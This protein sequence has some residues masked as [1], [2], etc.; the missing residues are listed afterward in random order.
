MPFCTGKGTLGP[1]DV[2]MKQGTLCVYISTGR[3]G[4]LCVPLWTMRQQC[5]SVG[6]SI[7]MFIYE[8]G[9]IICTSRN[10][11]RNLKISKALLN[12]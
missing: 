11:N 12:S 4:T 8:T 6:E 7:I 1:Y 5:P 3:K 9:K 2:C 10:R